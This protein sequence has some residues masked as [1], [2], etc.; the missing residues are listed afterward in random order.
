MEVYLDNSATTVPYDEVIEIVAHTMKNYYGNPSSAHRLGMEAESKINESREIIAKTLGCSKE[1]II[2]TSGGSESNN[3]LI[4][5][6]LSGNAHIIISRIEH[7]SIL[8]ICE[9]LVRQGVKVTYLNVD[10]KG[11][12]DI[13]ELEKAICKDTQLVSIMHVNNEI[14]VIQNIEAIG[15]LLKEKSKRIKFHVDAI[16][17]YGKFKIDVKEFNIDVLSASGHKIHGPRGI[18]FAYIKKGFMPKPLIFGG[19][20]EKNFRSGTEN[21]PAIVG[22]SKAAEI[23]NSRMK[24]NFN[25]VLGIKQYFIEKLDKIKDITINSREE[26]EFSPYILSVSFLGVRGEVLLH[27]LEEKGIYV[28]TGSACSSS[29]NK[30]SHVLKAIGLKDKEIDGTI[31]FSFSEYNSKEDIDYTIEILEESL[32]FLRRVYR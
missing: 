3:F 15:K 22:F 20:Q 29:S 9:E 17:S 27:T 25:E 10:N 7:P 32:K 1:E 30:H 5:G 23:I 24:E 6:F 12:V 4:K 13:D 26:E 21:V 2:F 18:G 11:R 31:R 16:Q 19:G 14:G 8:N 28:S